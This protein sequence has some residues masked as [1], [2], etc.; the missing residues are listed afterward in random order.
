M[1]DHSIL[2]NTN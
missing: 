1:R 2:H